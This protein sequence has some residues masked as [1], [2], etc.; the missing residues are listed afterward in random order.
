MGAGSSRPEEVLGD[1][2]IVFAKARCA[3]EALAVG[4][5]VI[6]A[7]VGGMA[8]MVTT[9]NL[10]TLRRLNFGW[11]SLARPLDPG[12]L[13]EE[14]RSYSAQDATRVA[15]KMR[16]TASLRKV[17]DQLL[18]LY[19][20]AITEYRRSKPDLAA[21]QRAVAAYLATATAPP[22]LVDVRLTQPPVPPAPILGPPSGNILLTPLG[23]VP[24]KAFEM[25]S[26]HIISPKDDEAAP[27]RSR[28]HRQPASP[29]VEEA[30]PSTSLKIC[31]ASFPWHF[32][33]ALRLGEQVPEDMAEHAGVVRLRFRVTGGSIGVGVLNTDGSDWLTRQ[34]FGETPA[35][36]DLLLRLARF[37]EAGQLVL[38]TWDKPTP[39]LVEIE[40]VE[41]YA[42]GGV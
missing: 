36:I 5:S 13:F 3:I 38:Q 8:G 24:L 34:A 30:P 40:L 6:T 37:D 20:A 21:E 4:C 32:A 10:D 15:K 31:T 17:V 11:R 22:P 25:I 9:E 12:A 18:H 27:A 33:A 16:D 19:Q 35:P 26:G 41:I 2:D 39:A 14:I 1:Y 7:D 28:K 29:D 42:V 23:L